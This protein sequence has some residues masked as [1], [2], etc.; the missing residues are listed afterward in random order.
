MRLQDAALLTA[1]STS[2]RD[3]DGQRGVE[4]AKRVGMMVAPDVKVSTQPLCDPGL[5]QTGANTCTVDYKHRK[6][7]SAAQ[8]SAIEA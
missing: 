8:G 5:C 7:F 4:H 3:I 2:V 6:D 1:S